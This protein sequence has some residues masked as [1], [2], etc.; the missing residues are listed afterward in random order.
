MKDAIDEEGKF[1]S[2]Q[3]FLG[4]QAMVLWTSR[5]DLA[6][7]LSSLLSNRLGKAQ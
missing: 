3:L 2:L 5:C 4:E 1:F 6:L 7:I